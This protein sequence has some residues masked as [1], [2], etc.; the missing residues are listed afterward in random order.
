M[1]SAKADSNP[2]TVCGTDS[3]RAPVS[4]NNTFL[5]EATDS[6]AAR[7]LAANVLPSPLRA[8]VRHT[9]RNSA[10]LLHCARI[11]GDGTYCCEFLAIE[12]VGGPLTGLPNQQLSL[13]TGIRMGY[14]F[15]SEV[16]QKFRNDFDVLSPEERQL[17]VQQIPRIIE[18]LMVES[19]T[20]GNI[21]RDDFLAAFDEAEGERLSKL[22]DY[23]PILM[24]E[25]Y[26]SLGL[27]SDG[28]TVVGPGLTGPDVERYRVAFNAM[29]LLNV[30]YLSRCCARVAQMMKR[31]EQ[32]L[33]D[34]AKALE[35]AVKAL[36][37][38][39][40]KSAAA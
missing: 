37:N 36:A 20:R 7:F 16:I 17:R 27:A 18:D 15:R 1:G 23:W 21:T 32:E 28:K 22:L 10:S 19:R 31:S 9:Q 26:K 2:S 4:T 33:S 24:R 29:R 12:E 39:D 11:Q 35:D 34:N 40:F 30:E 25:L 3:S 13:L 38:P 8:L 5:P 14:R 6:V